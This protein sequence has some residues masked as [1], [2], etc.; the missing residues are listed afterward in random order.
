[1]S[2]HPPLLALRTNSP[3]TET[4]NR[5]LKKQSVKA[6]NKKA[7]ETPLNESAGPGE[8]LSN[9]VPDNRPNIPCYRWVS[10]AKE[11]SPALSFSVPES[12]N[13]FP[14]GAGAFLLGASAQPVI[15]PVPTCAVTGCTAQRKYRLLGASDFETGA[16]GM[17]HLKLLKTR[18]V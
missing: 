5:L 12:T 15:R 1:V 14:Q 7:L 18:T 13:E 16:C 17:H 2:S 10:S 3:Q 8:E 9:P 4:I 6:R 11:I